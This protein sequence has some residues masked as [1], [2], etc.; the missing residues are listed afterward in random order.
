MAIYSWSR[1][2][3]PATPLNGALLTY[4]ALGN[5]SLI[6]NSISYSHGVFPSGEDCVDDSVADYLLNPVSNEH[7]NVSCEG[8]GLT[9]TVAAPA[10]GEAPQLYQANRNLAAVLGNVQIK[11]GT[12]YVNEVFRDPAQA[13]KLIEEIRDQIGRH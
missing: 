4:N 9:A 10:A 8:K 2:N 11:P 12:D 6:Y 1:I 3:D 13:R 7:T 5:A